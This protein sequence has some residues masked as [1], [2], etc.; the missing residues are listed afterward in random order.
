[1][2]E[3]QGHRPA[4]PPDMTVHPSQALAS[5]L[6]RL[7]G[8]RR[9]SQ[10]DIAERMTALGYGRAGSW[11]RSTAAESET[12]KRQ[13]TVDE[14][15]GLA[16]ILGVTI[17]ELLDPS[18]A[19]LALGDVVHEGEPQGAPLRPR[20]ARLFVRSDIALALTEHTAEGFTLSTIRVPGREREWMKATGIDFVDEPATE[21]G[22]D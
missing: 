11:K 17:G 15:V 10:E 2:S 19:S 20:V 21:T 16:M 8:L 18:D 9:L 4:E 13:V 1:M 5:N 22:E 14:L 7:R 3:A 6:R 12:G